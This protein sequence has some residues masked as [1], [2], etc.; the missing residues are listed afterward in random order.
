MIPNASGK[1]D[2]DGKPYRYYTCGYAHKEGTDAKCPVRH[3]S[4][5]ALET[6]VIGFLGACS[7][8]PDVVAATVTSAR[9]RRQVDRAPLRARLTELDAVLAKIND[10]LRNCAKKPK[11]CRRKSNGCSWS[12]NKSASN[13]PRA[14]KVKWTR[15]ASAPH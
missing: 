11:P 7:Q 15:P 9:E 6:A 5:T 8:H 4:A 1:L 3:V 10:Q 14:S 2:P 12:A 13:S